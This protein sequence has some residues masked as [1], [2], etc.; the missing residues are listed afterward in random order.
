MTQSAD[1]KG[2]G[3]FVGAELSVVQ[4]EQLLRIVSDAERPFHGRRGSFTRKLSD[5]AD[6]SEAISR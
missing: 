6:P 5:R 3:S 1:G 4:Q 2:R